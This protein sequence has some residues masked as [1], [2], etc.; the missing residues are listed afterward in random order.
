MTW[1]TKMQTEEKNNEKQ[2][3]QSERKNCLRKHFDLFDYLIGHANVLFFFLISLQTHFKWL[4]DGVE[5][6]LL[7]L[8]LFSSDH[9]TAPTSFRN[10][11][12][13]WEYEF[14]KNYAQGKVFHNGNLNNLENVL[15]RNLRK[16]RDRKCIFRAFGGTTF[17]D[18]PTNQA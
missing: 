13:V 3:H 4:N 8:H 15:Q 7:Q 9:L 10:T 18:V 2:K 11:N 5:L 17:E 6:Q 14:F 1:K 12:L 16:D